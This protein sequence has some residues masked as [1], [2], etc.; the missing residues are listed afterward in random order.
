MCCV[1]VA[2]INLHNK[3]GCVMTC[4]LYVMMMCDVWCIVY[5]VCLCVWCVLWLVVCV[6]DVDILYDMVVHVVCV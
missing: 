5:V 1:V 6:C 3:C 4:V 2:G